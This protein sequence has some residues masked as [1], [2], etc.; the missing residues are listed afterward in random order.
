MP[1]LRTPSPRLLTVLLY[2]TDQQ[3]LICSV[4]QPK[5]EPQFSDKDEDFMVEQMEDPVCLKQSPGAT[6]HR[7][8]RRS[9]QAGQT[10]Q[11]VSML[12]VGQAR[13]TNRMGIDLS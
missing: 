7:V 13:I 5:T 12:G 2:P 3:G 8:Q 10:R 6:S 4:S 11:R 9:R 1:K